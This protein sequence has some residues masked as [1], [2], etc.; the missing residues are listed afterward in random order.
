WRLPPGHNVHSSYFR[1]AAEHGLVGLIPYLLILVITFRD[2]SYVQRRA[3]QYRQWNDPELTRLA[4]SALFLQV[5]L[6]GALVGNL[7]QPTFHFKV[8]WL[9][10]ATGT[11]IHTM[12]DAR[13]RAGRA[14]REALGAVDALPTAPVAQRGPSGESPSFGDPSPRFS[15]QRG[16]ED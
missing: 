8:A 14:S 7:T 9:L 6:V 5:A 16:L 2:F 10:Y 13:L 1:I 12:M 3:R 4:Q 15:W 11:A